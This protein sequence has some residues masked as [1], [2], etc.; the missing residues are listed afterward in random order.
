MEVRRQ[1]KEKIQPIDTMKF[2]RILTGFLWI[3]TMM[4]VGATGPADTAKAEP[5]IL[6]DPP[7]IVHNRQISSFTE[8]G[9]PGFHL[10][11]HAG[12]GL[13][14]WPDIKLANGTIEFDVRGTNVF[15]K[16]FVGVAFHG[17]DENTYDA[18]YFR[19]FNFQTGDP[20]RR[21]HGVQYIAYP[22]YTWDRLR[23]EHPNKFEHEV[24][25]APSPDGWFHVR[26]E[27]KHPRVRAFVNNE[28]KPC[29][30]VGQLSDRKSGWVGIWVGNGSGGDFANLKVTPAL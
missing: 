24:S 4:L 22:S 29:L 18:V 30:E 17:L 2:K 25:P 16:S 8:N 23:A 1:G 28:E 15:Q 14:W 27:V 5:F 7:P 11:E 9:R 21:S 20:V 10:D 13:G 12:D 19:P 3:R 6:S 26:I